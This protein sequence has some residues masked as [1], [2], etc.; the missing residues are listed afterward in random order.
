MPGEVGVCI[1][2]RS[3]DFHVCFVSM[4]IHAT[5]DKSSSDCSTWS[6]SV[7]MLVWFWMKSEDFFFSQTIL[8]CEPWRVFGLSDYSP[9]LAYRQYGLV[10]FQADL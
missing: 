8:V 10:F 9:S 4:T 6:L 7:N 5:I 2:F 1:E 3:E